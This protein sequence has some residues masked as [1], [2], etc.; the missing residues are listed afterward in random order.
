MSLIDQKFKNHYNYY[1]TL[2]VETNQQQS[3]SL[4]QVSSDY[5]GRVLYELLQN[6]FDKSNGEILV[7]VKN[8]TLYIANDGDKFTYN[9]GF[10]YKK[11]NSK[12]CD[13][14]SLCSIAT[15]TKIDATSIGNKGVGFKSVFSVSSEGSVKIHTKGLILSKEGTT[16]EVTIEEEIS[17][18]MYDVFTQISGI[19]PAYPDDIKAYLNEN[20]AAVQEERKERGVPGYYFPLV[21]KN[22]DKTI[23]QLY[24]D[25]YVTVI[26]IPFNDE[27]LIRDL[28][29]EIKQ[30]HFKFVSL[31]HK[32]K[33]NIQFNFDSDIFKKSISPLDLGL[34]SVTIKNEKIAELAKQ[35]GVTISK[36]N[37]VGIYFRKEGNGLL[38]NY[39]P[40]Q[41][42]SPFPYVDFHADFHTTVDRRSIDFSKTTAIGKYNT[43]LLDACMELYFS[44]FNHYLDIKER[45]SLN[46]EIIKEET[47]SRYNTSFDWKFFTLNPNFIVFK[48][49]TQILNI[50]DWNYELGSS[51]ISNIAAKY[52]HSKRTLIEHDVFFEN[53]CNFLKHYVS[54]TQQYYI[55]VDRFKDSLA[56]K[57]RNSE[58]QILPDVLVRKENE[59]IYKDTG[60]NDL[61]LPSF[62]GVNITYFNIKDNHFKKALKIQNFSDNYP[63]LR[64][65]RQV[66]IDGVVSNEAINEKQQIELLQSLYEFLK[67][68]QDNNSFAHRYERFISDKL[69]ADSS[70][71]NNANFS[72]STV[73]LKVNTGKYKP[74]QLCSND[75]LDM[76]FLSKINGEKQSLFLKF[77]GVS[78]VSNYLVVEKPIYDK[79]KS[80]IDYIPMT[81]ERKKTDKLE[82]AKILPEIRVIYNTKEIHPALIN[83]NRYPFLE[84]ISYNRIREQ[85][86]PLKIGSYDDFPQAYVKE[87]INRL[88]EAILVYPSHVVRLY[89]HN[90]FDLFH[91]QNKYI[92][93]K[94]GTHKITSS[95]DFLIA[96]NKDEYELLSSKAISLLCH[97]NANEIS[98]PLFQD[99]KVKLKLSRVETEGEKIYITSSVKEKIY[100]YVPF[101]LIEISKMEHSISGRNYLLNSDDIQKF[102]EFLSKIEFLECDKITAIW[103]FEEK[104]ICIKKPE[105]FQWSPK[106]HKIYIERNISDKLFA[107]LIAKHVFNLSA[108]SDKIE[109][110]FGKDVAEIIKDYDKLDVEQINKFWIPDYLEKFKSF[111]KEIL[112]SFSE[113]ETDNKQLWYLYN[114][115]NQSIFLISL[116]DLGLIP[117]L[118]QQI[119]EVKAQKAYQEYFK[120]FK[121]EISR[122]H[123]EKRIG[124]LKTILKLSDAN[125]PL[126]EELE[127]LESKLGI[128]KRISEIESEVAALFPNAENGILETETKKAEQEIN[129]KNKVKSIYQKF[130]LENV[131]ET[132]KL[133]LTGAELTQVQLSR[134][135]KVIYKGNNKLA[136][137]TELAAMG[138]TGEEEVLL[139]FIS[140]FIEIEDIEQRII[141]INAVY[142][143]IQSVTDSD[144]LFD[145]LKD[146]CLSFVENDDQ[147]RRALI[148]FFYITLHFKFSN[149]DLVAYDEGKAVLIEVKT[150]D[151]K[152][153][154]MSISE[155]LR[156]RS[157]DNYIIVRVTSEALEILGNPVKQFE[158]YINEVKGKNIS[159][160]PRNY[161]VTII[162]Q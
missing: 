21:L 130:L 19:H 3:G 18:L 53:T 26:E 160:R 29:D 85:L 1:L 74:A 34:I 97:F 56:K 140:K 93:S 52:F 43:L 81:I 86:H 102:R 31:K 157:D 48:K 77:L 91:L 117:K 120:D 72:V 42:P 159:M 95:T 22:K 162:N 110:F 38:Y 46:I 78:P 15:S 64:Y 126:I 142:T 59:I 156:A 47:I 144:K 151:K 161:E 125:S 14:E 36:E 39:L 111:Q 76:E 105:P 16:E 35:A 4:Q 49:V 80:G 67:N 79:F 58:I 129:I 44:A 155:V 30:I 116:D 94:N 99:K 108:L 70:A 83:Y 88:Q 73:F 109:L 66:S 9:S 122:K 40:T 60:D 128:E 132:T 8:N 5:Q 41:K 136:T 158:E 71:Q 124:K 107:N 17:F 101:L 112:D 127:K 92:V 134:K 153:F 131:K 100:K 61:L 141:G 154:I 62:L 75:E 123:I 137:E 37:N 103:N 32:K 150:T 63:I 6:A 104:D 106:E 23:Q 11:G 50:S 147:L 139:Y 28:I 146:N 57:I 68:R 145:T 25:G 2:G 143:L 54:T 114:E 51:F 82:V 118:Q 27:Q 96:S 10:N 90:L 119:K 33:F 87:L 24:N 133:D 138:A 98:D 65:F 20:I 113:Y 12:R 55:W 135:K 7:E 45:S 13:F 89:A 148:P 69:R 84:D 149:F 152:S 115:H 121:L